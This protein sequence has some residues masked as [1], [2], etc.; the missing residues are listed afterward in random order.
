MQH[1]YHV[2]Q[3][4]NDGK[5]LVKFLEPYQQR[6]NAKYRRDKY[7]LA[8]ERAGG[9]LRYIVLRCER[10][11]ADCEKDA[12]QWLHVPDAAPSIGASYWRK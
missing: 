5:L 1:H 6:H 9:K 7:R 2:W 4:V 11:W 12:D 3:E 10:A 8:N